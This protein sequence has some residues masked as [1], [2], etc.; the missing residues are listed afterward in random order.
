MIGELYQK[1]FIYEEFQYNYQHV[2][3]KEQDVGTSTWE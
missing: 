3:T 2:Q 1:Q